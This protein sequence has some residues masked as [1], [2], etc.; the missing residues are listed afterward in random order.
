MQGVESSHELN[1]VIFYIIRL[2][3]NCVILLH[4]VPLALKWR[5]QKKI[6]E[7]LESLASRLQLTAVAPSNNYGNFTNTIDRSAKDVESEASRRDS[8]GSEK[9]GG[10]DNPGF[11]QNFP[12]LHYGSQNEFDASIFGMSPS[13]YIGP[14][15]PKNNGKSNQCPCELHH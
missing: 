13:Q 7:Q 14:P 3:L 4:V 1:E 8:N 15:I 9:M 10:V 6:L 2:I 5:K 11:V 12:Y